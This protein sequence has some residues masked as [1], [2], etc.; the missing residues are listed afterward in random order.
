MA[1]CHPLA[2]QLLDK[3]LLDKSR[4]RRL[5]NGSSPRGVTLDV[6][7]I[8]SDFARLDQAFYVH[9]EG[10]DILDSLKYFLTHED[11]NLRAKACSAVGNMCRHSSY[12]Y[13]AL[14]LHGIIHLLIDR[15]ADQDRRTQKFA[16]FAIG[17]AAYH[18]DLLYEELKGSVPQL[19]SLL[20]LP[21]EDKAKENTAAAL[22]NLVRNS[23]KL[24]EDMVSKGAMQAL[25]MLVRD[26]SAVALNPSRPEAPNESPL[27]IALFAL[28]KMCAYPQCR[29]FLPASEQLP[30]IVRLRQTPE[31]KIANYASV[32][33][34]KLRAEAPIQAT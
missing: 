8:I 13:K 24:C 30:I 34:S 21:E 25:M 3:G 17:N 27:K 11:S 6:L 2:V 33:L 16:C 14:A 18:N 26:Y 22:S 32:I 15:C 7:M 9:I 5:L 1:G 4:V 28:A 12:F 29:Q 23:D 19:A 31:P 20:L 10:A